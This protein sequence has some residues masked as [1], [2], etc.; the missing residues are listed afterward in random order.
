MQ[1]SL[2]LVLAAVAFGVP[3]LAVGQGG[4]VDIFAL[5]ERIIHVFVADVVWRIHGATDLSLVQVQPLHGLLHAGV[6]LTLDLLLELDCKLVIHLCLVLLS[7]SIYTSMVIILKL[8]KAITFALIETGVNVSSLSQGLQISS[9]SGGLLL[10]SFDLGL[11]CA[12]L[13]LHLFLDTEELIDGAF[14]GPFLVGKDVLQSIEHAVLG[15]CYLLDC[16][17]LLHLL[18]GHVAT[19]KDL[20]LRIPSRKHMERPELIRVILLL[21]VDSQVFT[22][23]LGGI[24]KFVDD[25]IHV[26]RLRTLLDANLVLMGHVVATHDDSTKILEG[27]ERARL[28]GEIEAVALH[29][30]VSFILTTGDVEGMVQRDLVLLRWGSCSVGVLVLHTNFFYLNYKLTQQTISHSLHLSITI[31]QLFANWLCTLSPNELLDIII[32]ELSV[33]TVLQDPV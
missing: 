1:H 12:Q 3:T 15:Y 9:S 22:L 30:F 20:V 17:S 10:L 26:G 33:K 31:R 14:L 18:G 16:S 5:F 28:L 24:Y 13:H 32:S 19:L 4:S 2:I 25:D 21:E 27:A 23:H 11:L 6:Q 7:L 8:T 29:D